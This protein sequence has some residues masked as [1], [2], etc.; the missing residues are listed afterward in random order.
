MVRSLNLFLEEKVYNYTHLNLML[1]ELMMIVAK[2]P[3]FSEAFY[4]CEKIIRDIKQA[5]EDKN[6]SLI[7]KNIST[8]DKELNYKNKYLRKLQGFLTS[9][10]IDSYFRDE[11]V[12]HNEYMDVYF[13]ILMS[14]VA[15]LQSNYSR[16]NIDFLRERFLENNKN[17]E[18]AFDIFVKLLFEKEGDYEMH[19]TLR[20]YS[21][22]PSEK[23]SCGFDAFTDFLK[24][25]KII[26]NI[27]KTEKNSTI[28]SVTIS[29]NSLFRDNFVISSKAK[30]KL[31]TLVNKFLFEYNTFRV[32]ILKDVK[33]QKI[34]DYK[35]WTVEQLQI[36]K[37]EYHVHPKKDSIIEK[38]SNISN[39]VVDIDEDSLFRIENSL[40]YYASFLHETEEDKKLLNLWIAFENLF[41]NLD[42]GD[43]FAK[44]KLVLGNLFTIY[45][46]RE[47]CDEFQQHISEKEKY[48]ASSDITANK[49]YLKI[50]KCFE[51]NNKGVFNSIGICKVL[52]EEKTRTEITRNLELINNN[53]FYSFKYNGL[54]KKLKKS[55]TGAYANLYKELSQS[56]R[57]VYWDIARIYRKRNQIVHGHKLG[58]LKVDLKDLVTLEY[59]YHLIMESIADF[60]TSEN[61]KI[62]SI[63][64]YIDRLNRSKEEYILM[65]KNERNIRIEHIVI[66][67]I[68]I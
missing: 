66:P 32:E 26:H 23:Q 5:Q 25:N 3:I 60:A 12:N 46:V 33:I 20:L 48:S 9:Y 47:H 56:E 14:F 68:V 16:K 6:Y 7:K 13:M 57:T 15:E 29:D 55:S 58:D 59:F 50:I 39:N 36:E 53:Y 45:Y 18:I 34:K 41:R 37:P 67:R 40:R 24:K 17:F 61:Y 44:I 22:F 38:F 4:S 10:L 54:A 28:F 42:D 63:S 49:M 8:L 2:D 30:I 19:F 35:V 21:D 31:L 64:E 52:S 65:I 27:V 11:Y 43:T 51:N 62:F 1:D